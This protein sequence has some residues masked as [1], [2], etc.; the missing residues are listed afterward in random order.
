[1]ALGRYGAAARLFCRFAAA[2]LKVHRKRSLKDRLAMLPLHGAP[3]AHPVDIYWDAH[4]IPFVDAQTDDDLAAALGIVHAHLRLGQMELMRIIAKGRVAEAVGGFGLPIDRLV[5]IFDIGRAVPDIIAGLPGETR[6]WLVGFARGINHCAAHA[7]EPPL[8]CAVLGLKFEP[9]SLADIVLLGRLIAADVNWIVWLRLLK[10]RDDPEWPQLWQKLL[11]HDTLSFESGNASGIA[12]GVVGAAIRSGSN[13][14]AVAAAR[15]Q[16]GGALI[17]ND[18]HLSIMLPNS[19]LL[20]GMKSPSH[21]AVGMMVPGIPFIGIGRNPWISWGAASL[22]AASSDLVAVPKD[23]P[24]RERLET[25]AVRGESD[26]VLRIRESPWGPVVSDTPALAAPEMLA[27]RWMG[28]KPSDEFTAMLRVGRARNWAEFRAA[29]DTY[30]LPGLEM[31]YADTA[32]HI[33]QLMAAKL[34]RRDN[35]LPDDIVSPPANGWETPYVSADLP[36][37]FD[38]E[39]GYLASANA[40]PE[41]NA[42]IVGFHFSPRNRIERLAHLLGGETRLSVSKLMEIQRDVHLAASLEHRDTILS[43]LREAG[44]ERRARPLYA[45]L[46]NWDGNYDSQSIGATAFEAVFLHLARA[47]VPPAREAAYE[48]AWGTRA[49]VWADILAA[50]ADIRANALARAVANAARDFGRGRPWGALHRLRLA[51]PFAALPIIGRRYRLADFP[52]SGTSET[53]MKTAHGLTRKRHHARYGSVA[54]HISDM[55]DPDANHFVLLGGQDGWLASS[56][57]ADQVALWRGSDY[58]TI[59]LSPAAVRERCVHPMVLRP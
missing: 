25:I 36:R 14:L 10:F 59:P 50:P 41:E 15:S 44:L 18:P 29:F 16:S 54:R 21:H 1:M 28:H 43:W 13:S 34:P 32:G 45:A 39:C 55:A 26:C 7:P 24:V 3:I 8:E 38:P 47:I 58:V 19:W 35:A 30:A 17:A 49:L 23:A 2:G 31:N 33:G 5:R 57:F 22:H 56:T 51:H 42:A 40:R 46:E 11:R 53:L 4:Q 52:A 9:W 20:A 48:A 6:S 12:R 27:L 37:R